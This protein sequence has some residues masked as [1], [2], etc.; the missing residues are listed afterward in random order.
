MVNMGLDLPALVRQ[1]AQLYDDHQLEALVLD[2]AGDCRG[3]C[4]DSAQLHTAADL[5]RVR[6]VANTL[7]Q[8]CEVPRPEVEPL[9]RSVLLHHPRRESALRLIEEY[10]RDAAAFN[11]LQRE[12]ERS[13]NP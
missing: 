9:V 12:R 8:L 2:W 3:L 7:A 10:V 4:A 11:K 13:T 1:V 5:L 6:C